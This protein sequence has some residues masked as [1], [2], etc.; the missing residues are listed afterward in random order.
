M[1]KTI[2]YGDTSMHAWDSFVD[3]S[4]NG[5]M[6]HKRRFLSYHP[7]GKFKDFSLLFSSNKGLVGVF[8]AAQK[9]DA[10]WSH[11]GASFG[12]FVLKD[13]GIKVM[14]EIVERTTRYAKACGFKSISMV[15]TPNLFHI[16]PVEGIEFAL[17]YIGYKLSA[18]ELSIVVDLGKN[19][20]HMRRHR[21]LREAYKHDI[22][23]LEC[24]KWEE[25][26]NMLTKNLRIRHSVKPTH[27]LEEILKLVHLFPEDIKL[28]GAFFEGKMIA[29][30]VT[31]RNNKTSFETFYI[32]QDYEYEKLRAIDLLLAGIMDA[33]VMAGYKYMNFGITSED[34]G[35]KINYGLAKFKEEFGGCDIVRRIYTREL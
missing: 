20:F 35:K 4:N 16:R 14:L 17:F 6:F 2:E 21:G 26:W 9:G 32:A 22:K 18:V 5:T 13:S 19:R 12:G 30:V 15:L 33:S 7:K 28:Y 23:I 29:G 24:D 11:P 34:R 8:P 27:T 31:F 3:S 10:L 25:Y 1:L